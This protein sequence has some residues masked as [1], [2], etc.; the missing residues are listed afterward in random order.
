MR[1]G[2]LD[3][4][5]RNRST[6]LHSLGDSIGKADAGA[7]FFL[8]TVSAKRQGYI[9]SDDDNALIKMFHS[10]IK[11]EEDSGLGYSGQEV[12]ENS[13]DSNR[14]LGV[15][16][17]QSI[18]GYIPELTQGEVGDQYQNHNPFDY[19]FNPLYRVDT[20]GF[21]GKVNSVA[22]FYLPSQAGADSVSY[23]DAEKEKD[24]EGEYSS[25][26]N[27]S[28]LFG[29]H[30]YGDL[31]Y[32][33]HDEYET[34]FGDW[35]KDK[36]NEELAL[37]EQGFSDLE[38]EHELRKMHMGEAKERWMS[39]TTD[40]N[41]IPHR[42]GLFDY[43][44]GLE[45]KSPKQRDEVY[46]HMSQWG[47][48]DRDR[49][50][51]GADNHTDVGRLV[52]NFQQRFT[53][54]ADHWTRDPMSPGQPVEFIPQPIGKPKI[55]PE[56]NRDALLSLGGDALSKAVQWHADR[57][58]VGISSD[59]VYIDGDG[60]LQFGSKGAHKKGGLRRAELLRLLNVNPSTGELYSDGEHPDYED[61]KKSDSPFSQVD[62]DNVFQH[63]SD[64][65]TSDDYGVMGENFGMWH[66]GHHVDPN[67]YPEDITGGENTTLASHWNK[68]FLG[69]GFGKLPN[70]LKNL[71]HAMTPLYGAD[72]MSP[73]GSIGI[74]EEQEKV[75]E[76][77]YG[78]FFADKEKED[79][80][81]SQQQ[82]MSPQRAMRSLLFDKNE[83]TNTIGIRH[84]KDSTGEKLHS[85]MLGAMGPWGSPEAEITEADEGG[86]KYKVSGGIADDS[87][88][89]HNPENKWFTSKLGTRRRN[90]MR[91]HGSLNAKSD[92]IHAK[93][94]HV[95]YGK[96]GWQG[97]KDKLSGKFSGAMAGFNPFLGTQEGAL[98]NERSK[99]RLAH[100]WHRVGTMR[101][102]NGAPFTNDN[103][104]LELGRQGATQPTT[105]AIDALTREREIG[106][107][108][109]TGTPPEEREVAEKQD[110]MNR[111]FER[112][113]N[114]ED[115]LGEGGLTEKHKEH[116]MHQL[117]EL[118]DEFD[119]LNAEPP[120]GIGAEIGGTAMRT[121][122]PAELEK[123]NADESAIA[124]MTG[125]LSQR[126]Q[127]SDP[128]LWNNLF[129]EHLPVETLD[130]NI[131]QLFRLGNTYLQ[132]APHEMHGLQTR[133]TGYHQ[134]GGD[135][136]QAPAVKQSVHNSENTVG[137]GSTGEEVAEMLNL[138]YN[139]E[140]NRATV[141]SLLE[142]LHSRIADTGDTSLRFPVMTVEQMLSSTNHYGDLGS[143]LSDMVN[144]IHDKKTYNK[145]KGTVN[146]INRVR[147][148][149]SSREGKA[150]TVKT[151]TEEKKSELGLD[152]HIAHNPDPSSKLSTDPTT[153]GKKQGSTAQNTARRFRALQDL[154]SILISDPTVEPKDLESIMG[155]QFGMGDV[156]IDAYGPHTDSVGSYYNSA[157][158]NFEMGDQHHDDGLRRHMHPTFDW[159][160]NPDTHEVEYSP[161]AE[162][163][164]SNIV[165]PLSRSIREAF[166]HLNHL[167]GNPNAISALS[168][169]GRQ[170]PQ[171]QP[172]ER[173]RV[174]L[175]N[176]DG[177]SALKSKIGL[178]DLTNPDIIRKD[179]GK[180]IPLLQPMHRIFK[181]E[182]LE[183]LRGFTGDW[184]VSVMPEGERG[185]V[186]KEDDKVTSP[187]FKLS[188][189]DKENFKK[190]ADDDYHVDVIKT[191]E[192]Y[193]VFDVIKFDGKEVHDTLLD[194]RIK[195]LRG[196]MEGVEN[197]HIPSASDT[198][199][200]DDG[201]LESTV[202]DLK[203]DNDRLLLRDAK[204]T[205][206]VGELRQPKWVLLSEGKDVVLIVLERRGSGPYTYR[207]GTGPITQDES[208]GDRAVEL[209]KETYMDV[210]AVFDSKEKFNEGDHVKVN[211]D[212]VG[213]SEFSEG[214]KLYTVTGSE[215]Q[216]EAESE[217]L[218]SQETLGL[219]AKSEI[220]QWLCEVTSVPSGI[221]IVMPQ[222]DV[223]YKATESGG[224]WSLHSPLANNSYLIRLSETQR[225][226]WGPVAG[227]ML[228]AGLEITEKEEVHDDSYEPGPTKPFIK[229]KKVKDTDWWKEE[230]KGKVLVK[231]LLLL[232]R[233]MKSGVGSVGQSSTGTMGLGID[234]ATP[235][236]SPTGPTN[237]HDS[238][239]MP[240]YDN[241]KRPGE[242]SSI[243][244]GT[245]DEKPV[246]HITIPV[247][248]GKLELTNDSATLRT[249]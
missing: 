4:L 70:E 31:K 238:K 3:I 195:I 197:I 192:G 249:Y 107:G 100:L 178:A 157:G 148:D 137:A 144:R 1:E 5:D 156:N 135:V 79:L 158:Y 10:V 101:H 87:Q 102:K 7:D 94:L 193:Y 112:M 114:I 48:N 12:Y 67:H 26:E 232:E 122:G 11:A 53:G 63:L 46:R 49:R 104:I 226:Y 61:W 97:I 145:N 221:R 30:H 212:N 64:A 113:R 174:Y 173:G 9:L 29:H 55:R 50:S 240:D 111:L 136:G 13:I 165:R 35:K 183:H 245:Q 109:V 153:A 89:I 18:A 139:D 74:G 6:F 47:T 172:S 186:V 228:K 65:N 2:H 215:I 134:Q 128:E 121:H 59:K 142:K 52:R 98:N 244:P 22:N 179:L 247:E 86:K 95:N 24:I 125:M 56:L 126:L 198:R 242:D 83:L 69:G 93:E 21:S 199:L 23:V 177:T 166:P 167:V 184:I 176:V 103:G 141:D 229:P 170:P 146:T 32:S 78:Q 118:E 140:R 214:H 219:L 231:G 105:Q 81:E 237:L 42:L 60:N 27:Y 19:R 120:E 80:P 117:N 17:G 210:G 90:W 234:Y 169:I 54:M 190:V 235:I 127:A 171:F 40:E 208:L 45:W 225:P 162:G 201:G 33:N 129:G 96:P 75:D 132:Q 92:N 133:S 230:D 38:A 119:E 143:G 246:K 68:P 159:H 206:M 239:T 182:D 130:A 241:K 116:L 200:T 77:G 154:N 41:G 161:V 218:V 106:M 25:D 66:Y 223:V 76:Y 57:Q 243:E 180:D 51:I 233:M 248:E 163:I 216:G 150:R 85:G 82:T 222:G 187:S 220:K 209:N 14:V 15:Q 207:L 71:L 152:Y 175:H 115:K 185:F 88:S 62:V 20:Q 217:G 99:R 39:D 188:D 91:H 236:E 16:P 196:G 227:T 84:Y 203:K 194:A 181:L 213:E 34:H 149:L 124:K 191:E 224:N 37:K 138:D 204:S 44:F 189:E 168:A 164:P 43:L 110:E 72:K 151:G 8:S 211:V 73:E 147:R 28:F 155:Q 58:G 131:R 205:Y 123:I 108:K 36:V 160:I 202:E